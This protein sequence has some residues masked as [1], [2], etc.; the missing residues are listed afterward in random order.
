MWTQNNKSAL[1]SRL[2]WA[3][4]IERSEESILLSRIYRGHP[5]R[6]KRVVR[7]RKKWIEDVIEDLG[8]MGVRM[9]RRK[10]QDRETWAR[11]VKQALDRNG[12]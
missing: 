8:E 3:G 12:P 11:I 10:A 1:Q 2:R 9:W 6:K 5:G 7:P 4:H